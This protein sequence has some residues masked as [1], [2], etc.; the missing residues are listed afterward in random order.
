[1]DTRASYELVALVGKTKG[2]KGELVVHPPVG[3]A[4]R[5]FEGLCAW[6]VPPSL[7]GPRVVRVS[8]VQRQSKH[9]LAAFEEIG[10]VQSAA[11][12][13]GRHLLARSSDLD[14]AASVA[15]RGTLAHEATS[16]AARPAQRLVGLSV[17]DEQAGEVGRVVRVDVGLAQPLLVVEGAF[18]TV[19]VPLVE[20]FVVSE[21]ADRIDMRL[22]QGLLDLNKR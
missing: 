18:G 20:A 15:L 5:L 8:S 2:L 1:M 3:L 22:P 10:D 4:L 6:V 16:F 9:V 21:G 13:S 17:Y 12:L 19:L 14:G 11:S 7:D